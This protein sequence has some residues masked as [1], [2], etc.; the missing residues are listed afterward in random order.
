MPSSE[1]HGDAIDAVAGQIAVHLDRAGAIDRAVDYYQQAIDG[2]A[3]VFAHEEVIAFARRALDL[4][5]ALPG[6]CRSR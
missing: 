2:A 3:H 1:L 4:L 6:Q 5:A